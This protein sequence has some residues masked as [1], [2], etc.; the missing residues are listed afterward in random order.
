MATTSERN[1]NRT[2]PTKSGGAKRKRQAV[3]KKRLVSLGMDEAAVAAMNPKE[4]LVKLKHPARVAKESAASK[5][6]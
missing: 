1:K 3:Q 2:R 5:D 6:A 4:V